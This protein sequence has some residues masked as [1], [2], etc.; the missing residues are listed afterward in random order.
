MYIFMSDNSRSAK[1]GPSKMIDDDPR[2]DGNGAC[3]PPGRILSKVF[4]P[5]LR[6]QRVVISLCCL[7]QICI[8]SD[9]PS[10]LGKGCCA[11]ELAVPSTS[12]LHFVDN[13]QARSGGSRTIATQGTCSA[14]FISAGWLSRGGCV[15]FARHA[16]VNR[17]QFTSRP[18]PCLSSW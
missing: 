11:T 5:R 10:S 7:A 8:D 13:S 12:Y 14:G 3:G 9:L 6:F 2:N 18:E 16:L 15:L 1:K 17:I 4:T